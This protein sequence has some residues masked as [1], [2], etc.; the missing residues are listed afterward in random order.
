MPTTE[1]M[2]AVVQRYIAALNAADLEAIVALYA[3]DAQVEDPVGSEPQR[4]HEAIRAF[5]ARSLAMKL[6]VALQGAVRAVAG[7][8]AFAFTVT[9]QQGPR[10]LVIAPIDHFRFD[11]EG[12]ITHMRAF[13]GPDNTRTEG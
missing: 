11:A 12:R 6:E 2:Q 1:H 4:G 3:P 7:E 9:L 10:R 13:F 8:A 5:Y